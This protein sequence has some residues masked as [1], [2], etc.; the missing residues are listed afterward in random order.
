MEYSCSKEK[1]KTETRLGRQK[2]RESKEGEDDDLLNEEFE[3]DERWKYTG[4]CVEG[5]S[6]MKEECVFLPCHSS[7]KQDY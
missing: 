3:I 7:D 5:K 1:R 4:V 6:E 2:D